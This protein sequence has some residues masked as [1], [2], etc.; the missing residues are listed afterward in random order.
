[1]GSLG[2]GLGLEADA[3][4]EDSAASAWR[5]L[6]LL[7]L[8]K[9]ASRR[10][11]GAAPHADTALAASMPAHLLPASPLKGAHLQG[12]LPIVELN[13]LPGVSALTGALCG[14]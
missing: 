12:E 10:R 7:Q 8:L 5:S 4:G 11:N 13:H 3:D 9:R 2:L 6:G 14:K 1:M